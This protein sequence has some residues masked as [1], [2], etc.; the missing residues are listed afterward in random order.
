M[1]SV[2][3]A[4]TRLRACQEQKTTCKKEVDANKKTTEQLTKKIKKILSE[5]KSG[6]ITTAELREKIQ[7]IKEDSLKNKNNINLIKCSLDHCNENMKEMLAANVSMLE[8][9]CKIS[10]DKA[11]CAKVKEIKKLTKDLTWD[12]YMKIIQMLSDL[13]SMT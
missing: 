9:V 12:N 13:S 2:M 5:L 11:M 1:Q 4:Q 6:K 3:D 10:S 7:K 8:K